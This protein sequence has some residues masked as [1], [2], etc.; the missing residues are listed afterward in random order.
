MVCR[1]LK[2]R[3]LIYSIEWSKDQRAN[4]KDE[5]A[6]YKMKSRIDYDKKTL[7]AIIPKQSLKLVKENEPA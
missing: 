2:K 3:L 4:W 5:H 1:Y 7:L 6:I